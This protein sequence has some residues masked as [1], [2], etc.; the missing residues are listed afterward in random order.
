MARASSI[1]VAREF[2]END[3]AGLAVGDLR[4]IDDAGA[5][6]LAD[7]NPVQKNKDRQREV[8]VEKRFRGGEL[9]DAASLIEAVEAGGAQLNEAGFEGFRERGFG[10]G[11]GGGFGRGFQNAAGGLG[12]G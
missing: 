8:Q 3:F 11:L 4:G 10:G 2:L 1:F 12:F 5:V 7:D 9:E 6:V